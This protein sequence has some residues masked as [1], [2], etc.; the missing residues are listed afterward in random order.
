MS[1]PPITAILTAL[2]SRR[3]TY[4][5]VY[6]AFRYRDVASGRTVCGTISGGES[7]VRSIM[8]AMNGG[9]WEPRTTHYEVAELPIR[10]FNRET[11]GWDYAGC[12]GEDLAAFIR[13]RLTEPVTL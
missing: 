1:N 8:Y 2:H 10:A 13:E 12:T 6:W 5:N 9:S 4:G 11:K 3:D 7:N